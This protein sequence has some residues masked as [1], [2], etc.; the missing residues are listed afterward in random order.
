MQLSEV[1]D[2]LETNYTRLPTHLKGKIFLYRHLWTYFQ[3]E[4]HPHLTSFNS[5]LKLRDHE[6]F[7]EMFRYEKVKK[8]CLLK[9]AKHIYQSAPNG[10]ELYHEG[11][12]NYFASDLS[13]ISDLKYILNRLNNE[14]RE[15]H[16]ENEGIYVVLVR[17]MQMKLKLG[18][19]ND[20][21]L[22]QVMIYIENIPLSKNNTVIED[23][24]TVERINDESDRFKKMKLN[25]SLLEII[26]N[27]QDVITALINEQ[28]RANCVLEMTDR[29]ALVQAS[30]GILA[31][32]QTIKDKIYKGKYSDL[33]YFIYLSKL[34]ENQRLVPD[35]A[36]LLTDPYLLEYYCV[37]E[38]LIQN[39]VLYM[40]KWK[41]NQESTFVKNKD[42][43]E[44][45]LSL[46]PEESE[47]RR[48]IEAEIEFALMLST[49]NNPIQYPLTQSETISIQEIAVIVGQLSEQEVAS[50]DV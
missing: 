9:D 2:Y 6:L 12:L 21:P 3:A 34:L 22:D 31:E 5:F 42:Y 11:L 39:L 30:Y 18:S 41:F 14:K 49:P 15:F 40:Y 38:R 8:G 48:Y 27:C 1:V 37:D 33:P 45:L 32:V 29:Q 10:I 28:I 23:L 43:L 17:A 19:D 7:K 24:K 16:I 44:A 35:V 4:K 13:E 26:E 50:L 46:L 36:M 47:C 25:M 20:I